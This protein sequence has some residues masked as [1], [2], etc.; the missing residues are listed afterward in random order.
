MNDHFVD[1]AGAIGDGIALDTA[2]IQSTIDSAAESGG[3]RVV[4]TAGKTYL[5]GSIVLRS[6]IELHIPA[7]AILL[8]SPNF[9]DYTVLQHGVVQMDEPASAHSSVRTGS[10][11]Y[12]KDVTNVAISGSGVIDGN[13]RNY[14]T[15]IGHQIHVAQDERAFTLHLRD[16]QRVS[17]R[18]IRIVDGALWTVRLSRCDDV[19]IHGITIENDVRMPNSDGI[20]IDTCRR[21]RISDCDIQAGDDAICLKAAIESTRDGR[22]C[23]NIVITGCTLMSSSTAVLCGVEC[24][25]AI[26]DVIVSGCVIYS[27]NRGLAVSLHERGII[28]RVRFENIVV[29]TSLFDERWWGRGEPIYVAAVARSTRVGSVSQVTFR[30]ITATSPRG[31]FVYGAKEGSVHD[32]DITDVQLRLTTPETATTD[33]D[34]ADIRPAP[35]HGIFADPAV[36]GRIHGADRVWMTNIRVAGKEPTI[37][38]TNSRSVHL[39]DITNDDGDHSPA[40]QTAIR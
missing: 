31:I 26:R 6:N 2:A 14:V 9:A 19:V 33:P 15:E 29:N 18:D 39:R 12:G 22:V 10:F 16:V 38:V 34:Y 28:E 36:A 1:D 21:V 13:G 25:T 37:N 24:D 27:S 3:G 5:A 23:E 17:I 35:E 40:L 7:G 30:G 11:V 20:D 32:I 8:A 4:L